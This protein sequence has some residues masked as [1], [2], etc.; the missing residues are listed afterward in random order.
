MASRPRFDG[1]PFVDA[2]GEGGFRLAGQR[3]E[4]SV[5]ITP[6]GLF[7]WAVRS[8]EDATS[9][10]FAPVLEA[11]PDFDFLIVGSGTET[12]FLPPAV[13]R[14][15]ESHTIFPDVMATGPACRT[16]NLMLSENRRVAAALVAVG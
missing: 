4:G 9:A 2:Y 5:L 1:Q 3:F 10:S 11:S 13:R 7:P 6:R 15:L 16:Y 8:V 12:A 14:H